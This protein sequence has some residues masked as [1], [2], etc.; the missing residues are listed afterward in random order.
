MAARRPRGPPAG[1]PFVVEPRLDRAQRDAERLGDLAE[2]QVEVVVQHEDRALVRRKASEPA[3]ERVARRDAGSCRV[4][5]ARRPT[6]SGRWRTSAAPASPRRSRHGRGSGDPGFE[7]ID[8]AELR[9][10]PP[11]RH[12]GLLHGILGSPDVAQD[13][14]RNGEEPISRATGDRGECLFVPGPCRFDRASGPPSAPWFARPFGNVSPIMSGGRGERFDNRLAGSGRPTPEDGRDRPSGENR[15]PAMRLRARSCGTRT[16]HTLTR[17]AAA[18]TTASAQRA[19]VPY[20]GKCGKPLA[21]VVDA[22]E[23]TFE[24]ETRAQPTVVLDLW[25]PWC[26]PCASSP[27]SSTSSPTSTPAASR[28]SRSTSTRTRDSPAA[29]MR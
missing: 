3:V 23:S 7:A 1:S 24:V 19:G 6:A 14:V 10:L 13:P 29:S 11:G 9:K 16:D 22:N 20:R 27:R 26:G 25:A 21:W 2:W 17:P 8:L 28:W 5:P 15:N 12:E 4:S 18:R